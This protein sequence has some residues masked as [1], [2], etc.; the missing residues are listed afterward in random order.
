MNYLVDVIARA[1]APVI[2]LPVYV[3]RTGRTGNTHELAALPGVVTPRVR[4]L[5]VFHAVIGPD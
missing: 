3:R 2:N 5:A 4:E 1:A